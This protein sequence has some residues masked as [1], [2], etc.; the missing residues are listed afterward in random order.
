[1]MAV[2]ETNVKVVKISEETSEL[3]FHKDKK[4]SKEA[5]KENMT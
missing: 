2:G 5:Q 1:M 4:N 3:H